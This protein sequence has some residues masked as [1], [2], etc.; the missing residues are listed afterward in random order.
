MPKHQ[1]LDE[2]RD[3]ARPMGARIQLTIPSVLAKDEE[4]ALRITAFGADGLPDDR[5]E[6][7]LQFS[8]SKGITGLPDSFAL[9]PGSDGMYCIEELKAAGPDF[10][11]VLCELEDWPVV[12][13]PA[14]VFDD[15][16]YRVHWGDTHVHTVLSRC[17]P[18]S[19]KSPE[20]CYLFA[21]DA[22]HLDF[23]AAADHLRGIAWDPTHWPRL[24]KCAADF[25]DDG[26]FVTLLGFESSH[27]TGMGGDNNIY[28]LE[29]DSPYF[30]VDREDMKGNAPEVPLE[31]LWKFC[32]ESGKSFVSVPHHTGR[33]GKYRAFNNDTYDANVE[34]VFEIYSAWG[35]SERRW[36]EYPLSNGNTDEPA[37]FVDT[38]KEG[39][40]YGVIASSDDHTTMPGAESRNWGVAF[41]RT[42]ANGYHHQG[43]AAVRTGDLRRKSV[44]NAL[45]GRSTYATTFGRALVDM[46]LGGATMGQE[47][48][49]GKS[50]PLRSRREIKVR[51]SSESP[52]GG[53]VVLVRNGEELE[54]TAYG[55]D[56]DVHEICLV[57]ESDADDVAI[58]E[59]RHHPAPFIAYYV[60]VEAGAK[61]KHWTSPIWVDVG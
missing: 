51:L 46:T 27:K 29:D 10:A 40:R 8:G 53:S 22:A 13:N 55:R 59:A 1:W 11:R 33:R 6:G 16:P 38:L 7:K 26:R 47:L 19:C 50:D 20:F 25:N 35:S 57:D 21:R 56:G 54:R 17:H 28:Y 30:W 52:G 24:Q 2:G 12:S 45:R 44:F 34:P 15:P 5:F 49:L 18:W 31:D 61:Q 4:F 60:R 41:G 42:G 37:Y 36:N 3:V 48:T 9:G 23:A 58:R 32:A 14:W 39:C 43:L